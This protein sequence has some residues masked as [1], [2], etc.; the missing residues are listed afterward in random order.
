MGVCMYGKWVAVVWWLLITSSYFNKLNHEW[1]GKANTGVGRFSK[2]DPVLIPVLTM[3]IDQ[4]FWMWGPDWKPTSGSHMTENRLWEVVQMY[5]YIYMENWTGSLIELRSGSQSSLYHL[6]VPLVLLLTWEYIYIYIYTFGDPVGSHKKGEN[7]PT[8]AN[9]WFWSIFWLLLLNLNEEIIVV[10]QVLLWVLSYIL[11]KWFAKNFKVI[12]WVS[13]YLIKKC[14]LTKKYQNFSSDVKKKLKI[15]PPII[16]N[17]DLIMKPILNMA[18][19]YRFIFP[20]NNVRTCSIEHIFFSPKKSSFVAFLW[21]LEK[22][23]NNIE[24]T[25]CEIIELTHYSTK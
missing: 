15:P 22:K 5:I 10:Y 24:P 12:V 16:I 13:S 11:K 3:R 21:N 8:L 6:L 2:A 4:H 20:H 18:T 9:T 23:K 19:S 25:R 7:R 14:F 17:G 1:G